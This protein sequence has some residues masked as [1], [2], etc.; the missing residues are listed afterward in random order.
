MA[1]VEICDMGFWAAFADW[2]NPVLTVM[3]Y[4]CVAFGASLQL[5]LQ[6]KCR[7]TLRRWLLVALCVVGIVVSE[8]AW[9]VITGC[10]KIGV[11][12]IYGLIICLLL[13]A[14]AVMLLSALQNTK[15]QGGGQ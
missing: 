4:G 11:A 2:S 13:G 8:C 10:E 15:K 14:A 7:R 3:I 12:V 5:L 9:Q 1:L 6:R